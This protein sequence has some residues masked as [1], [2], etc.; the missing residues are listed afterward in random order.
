MQP[1]LVAN[2]GVQTEGKIDGGRK[3]M[4][5]PRETSCF[6]KRA[7]GRGPKLGKVFPNLKS[8]IIIAENL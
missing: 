3:A 1:C 4:P 6:L 2:K 5:E 7:E 8:G